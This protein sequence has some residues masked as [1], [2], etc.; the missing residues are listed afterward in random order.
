ML[1]LCPQLCSFHLIFNVVLYQLV[2]VMLFFFLNIL[3]YTNFQTYSRSCT[4]VRRENS[5]GSTV[6]WQA[7]KL[8]LHEIIFLSSENEDLW[9]S[10]NDISVHE[11]KWHTVRVNLS[12]SM[13]SSDYKVINYI[14]IILSV[15]KS[16]I[17]KSSWL[18]DK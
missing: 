8:F 18:L 17:L 10:V 16:L 7:D 13:N 5:R 6:M 3:I 9:S 4:Q 2:L 14:F 15:T 11:T 12:D 1:V